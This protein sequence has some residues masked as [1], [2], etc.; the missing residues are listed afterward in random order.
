MQGRWIDHD[1]SILICQ[2]V[3]LRQALDV[4]GI[5]IEASQQDDDRVVLLCVISLGQSNCEH[6]VD[7]IDGHLFP[8]FLRPERLPG[9]QSYS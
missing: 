6:P 2:S 4:V 1:D 7:V 5:L 9:H 8:G 3:K